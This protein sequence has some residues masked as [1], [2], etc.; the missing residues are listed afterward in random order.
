MLCPVLVERVAELEQL[1]ACVEEAAAGRGGVVVLVGEA[2]VG[3]TRLTGEVSDVARARGFTT[4]SG[5]AVA[6]ASAVPYRPLTEA[7]LGAFRSVGA[8]KARELAGF[9]GQL[10]R[11]VPEWRSDVSGGADESPVLLGEAV[12]RLLR[13]V[14]GDGGCLLVLEDLH[15]ADAE[16]LAVVD[17]VA[18]AIAAEAILCV[19]TARPEGMALEAV[20]RLR[21]SAGAMVLALSSLSPDGVDQAVAACLDTG[22]VPHDVLTFVESN[23]EGNP[24]LIEELLSGLAASGAIGL[25][26]GRWVTTGLLTPSV[27][28]DFGESIQR[29]LSSLGDVDRRV[30]R[31]AALLGRRFDWELVAEVVDVDVGIVLDALRAAVRAQVVAVE[32]SGFMF[33]HALTP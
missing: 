17:Y 3:K 8:P 7:F 22:Q 10:G 19:C 14:G 15:W 4:L 18:D 25:E 5:R 20:S 23:S 12:V 1:A 26:Q 11:L 24:F 32:G 13:I 2:G 28:F 31:A 21:R 6:G 30:V 29:R 9:G 33:R 16:T 27:P